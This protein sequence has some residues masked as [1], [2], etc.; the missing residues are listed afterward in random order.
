MK[1]KEIDAW[2][3]REDITTEQLATF[4]GLTK[5]A[6]SKW[7][8]RNAIPEK[9]VPRL[10]EILALDRRSLLRHLTRQESKLFL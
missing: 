8:S 4:L 3:K 1:V 6:I 9:L 2:L 10:K 5:Y 7:R